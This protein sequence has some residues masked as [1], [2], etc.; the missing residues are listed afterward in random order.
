MPFVITNKKRFVF[1]VSTLIFLLLALIFFLITI[2]FP[3][4]Y[5]FYFSK[6]SPLSNENS[7]IEI[8]KEQFS[9]PA[10]QENAKTQENDSSQQ[11]KDE[12]DE[13]EVEFTEYI[14][15]T[16]SYSLLFPEGWYLNNDSS[17]ESFEEIEI[18]DD[19]MT[20]RGG[21]TFLSNYSNINAYSPQDKPDDF[22]ILGLTVYKDPSETIEEFSEKLSFFSEDTKKIKFDSLTESG[23]E[24]VAPGMSE[25]NPKLSVFFKKNDLFYVFNMAFTQGNMETIASMENIIHSFKLK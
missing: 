18:D 22:Y 13:K 19:V 17:E 10:P 7:S 15:Q 1:F 6:K 3:E 24:M 25:E 14:N 2:F 20:E 5:D 9:T 21:S 4:K 23:F 11:D 16:Y 8:S 12:K